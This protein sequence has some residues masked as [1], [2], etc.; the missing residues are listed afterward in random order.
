MNLNIPVSPSAR[1]A[2]LGQKRIAASLIC[3]SQSVTLT[4][5]NSVHPAFIE[6]MFLN[7]DGYAS[8]ICV[9]NRNVSQAKK[10]L[11]KAPSLFRVKFSIRVEINERGT[12]KREIHTSTL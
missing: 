8:Y 3:C 10:V 6:N 7:G 1:H 11:L 4:A 9:F 2:L 12:E 5:L